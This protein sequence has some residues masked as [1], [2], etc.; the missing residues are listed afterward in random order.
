MTSPRS[1]VVVG[2][3]VAGLCCAYYLRRLG[4]EVTVVESNRVG[5]GA[6]W[7]NGGWVCPAQAG[8]LPEPGLTWYGIRS[9]LDRD[10]P[11]YFQATKLPELAPWLLRFWTYCN[12]GDHQHGV[13]TLAALGRDVFDLVEEM[14][15][16]GVEFELHRQG[17]LVAARKPETARGELEKLQPMRAFGYELPD[18]LLS[19]SDLRDLEPALAD[20][21]RGGFEVRQHWHVRPDSFTAGIAE[22][23]R[24]MDVEVIEG[25][26]VTDFEAQNGTVTGVRTAA[27]DH[28][29]DAFVLAAGAWTTPVAR[30]LGVRLPM[31]GGKGYSF[32]VNPS[33]MPSHSILLAD[34]HVGCT[35][36]GDQ[37][38]I[39]G[40][41]EFSGLNVRLDHKRINDITT[42][43]RASFQPWKSPEI[44]QAWAGMRPITPD[45]LPVL[46]RV[47]G[48]NVY[49]A[50]GYSMQGVTLAPPAGRAM[51]EFITSGRRPELLEPFTIERLQGLRR[52]RNG[53][54]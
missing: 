42:A 2:G 23:L 27:G 14:R 21:V 46:D 22:A 9:L 8:P 6:S 52:R 3:G 19:E 34:V 44:E 36:L 28:S 16:D 25:A 38:R 51:A 10:S 48:T 39:G 53:H 49:L 17:M 29:A 11:L 20:D 54:G 24:R 26:E 33:V 40:T 30:M 32:F 47:E 31:Q 41:M 35:P 45:G 5:S 15:A 18:D 43:A 7:G 4:V 50:T 12:A 1:V 13:R 37:M